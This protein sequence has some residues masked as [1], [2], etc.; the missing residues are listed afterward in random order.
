M[1]ATIVS[2]GMVEAAE[3]TT[4]TYD[5]TGQLIALQSSGTV[6]G[7]QSV[8]TTLDP[9]GNRVLYSVTGVGAPAANLTIGSASATEGGVLSFT[10]TRSGNTGISSSANY[11]TSNGTSTSGSYFTS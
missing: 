5:A 2:A 7:G 8:A 9:A 10:V 3:T 4:Y 11:A 6:N 1:L